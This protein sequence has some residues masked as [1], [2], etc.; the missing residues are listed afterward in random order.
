MALERRFVNDCG[1]KFKVALKET[2]EGGKTR[3]WLLWGDHVRI[4]G[5]SGA[6]ANV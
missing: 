6:F 1:G 5:T 4:V 2:K 3:A